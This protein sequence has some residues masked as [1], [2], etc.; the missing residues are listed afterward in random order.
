MRG[1]DSSFWK[2]FLQ[3]RA[4]LSSYGERGGVGVPERGRLH[5]LLASVLQLRGLLLSSFASYLK[6]NNKTFTVLAKCL[7]QKRLWKAAF[8]ERSRGGAYLHWL[9]GFR[10]DGCWKR[11]F[12][13]AGL[14]LR[15]SLPA[16][17]AHTTP[18]CP[19]LQH[20]PGVHGQGI[21]LLLGLLWAATA[22]VRN[23]RN[24]FLLSPAPFLSTVFKIF[25][26]TF[27]FG[28]SEPE[29]EKR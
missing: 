5:P 2:L 29:P 11:R 20:S 26:S 12:G 6:N 10:L 28:F 8:R 17:W 13:G 16:P 27:G 14:V 24:R 7:P 4:S 15:W 18:D 22:F 25:F 21:L 9:C 1:P 19:R 23:P 3:Q